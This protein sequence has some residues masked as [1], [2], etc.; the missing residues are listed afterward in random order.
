MPAI[1][2]VRHLQERYQPEVGI[3][4]GYA[5]VCFIIGIWRFDFD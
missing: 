4:L 2:D 3:F 5:V 1:V